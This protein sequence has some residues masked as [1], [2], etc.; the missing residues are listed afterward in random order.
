LEEIGWALDARLENKRTVALDPISVDAYERGDS[1]QFALKHNAGAWRFARF[2][3]PRLS[4]WLL[5]G[6]R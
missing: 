6:E 2:T 4:V 1:V 5:V 3:E